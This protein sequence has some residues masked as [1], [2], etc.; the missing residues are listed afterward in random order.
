MTSKTDP[1]QRIW[2]LNR[3]IQHYDLDEAR[4]RAYRKHVVDVDTHAP[5][6][7]KHGLYQRDGDSFAVPKWYTERV[8]EWRAERD[9][10]I[11]FV[12]SDEEG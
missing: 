10:L 3:F 8:N 2:D 6:W 1:I 7:Y 9:E 5:E 11:S 4:D 12:C